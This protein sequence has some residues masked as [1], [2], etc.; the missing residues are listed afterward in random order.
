MSSNRQR[1]AVIDID[2]VLADVRHRLHHLDGPQRDWDAFFRAAP[3]D[4]VLA[5]G[6][7]A[8]ER[9]L[10]EGLGLVYLTGRPERCR[11]A[12][13]DWLGRHDFP[14]APLLMRPDRD[15]RPAR[16][17]KIASLRELARTS[18]VALVVDDDEAVV[19]AVAAAGFP[20]VQATWMTDATDDEGRDALTVAQEDLGRT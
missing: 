16:L 18:D 2:G 20:I 15:R 8:V 11:Q 6:R 9:V 4:A 3:D 17:F 7:S 13:L 10:A 5:G 14:A 12:T 1:L 19:S